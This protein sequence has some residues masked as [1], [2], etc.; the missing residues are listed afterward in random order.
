MF[1]IIF[2]L[3]L[4]LAGLILPV[5]GI[6][7]LVHLF[8]RRS[9]DEKEEPISDYEKKIRSV[10]VY[11]LLICLLCTIIVSG[12]IVFN[13]ML[14]EILPQETYSSYENSQSYRVYESNQTMVNIC[15]ALATLGCTIPLFIYHSN[16][17]KNENTK[18]K[19]KKEEK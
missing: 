4:F 1:E 16:I 5:I 18:V 8:S 13:L 2:T 11:F 19:S 9:K 3:L 17:A 15:T 12:I 14:N 6:I 10:Y 7:F